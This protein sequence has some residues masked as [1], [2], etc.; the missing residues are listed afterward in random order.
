MKLMTGIL[1]SVLRQEVV[2]GTGGSEILVVGALDIIVFDVINE[3]PETKAV[4][5]PQHDLDDHQGLLFLGWFR[6]SFAPLRSCR[7]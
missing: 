1:L 6:G 5:T 4:G 3:L 2:G 7:H